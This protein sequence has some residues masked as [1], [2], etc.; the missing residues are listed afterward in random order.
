VEATKAASALAPCAAV[1]YAEIAVVAMS[2]KP[3]VVRAAAALA[4]SMSVAP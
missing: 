4:S 1:A 2:P 3:S